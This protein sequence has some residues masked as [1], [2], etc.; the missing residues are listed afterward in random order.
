MSHVRSH[1][2]F[3]EAWF[4]FIYDSRVFPEFI[5]KFIVYIF[6]V[7]PFA[8]VGVCRAILSKLFSLSY[9][10]ICFSKFLTGP[11]SGRS[12]WDYYVKYYQS[13]QTLLCIWIMLCPRLRVI[14][15]CYWLAL[16]WM[17][18][19]YRYDWFKVKKQTKNKLVLLWEIYLWKVLASTFWLC[20]DLGARFHHLHSTSIYALITS[21]AYYYGLPFWITHCYYF[22]TKRFNFVPLC[23]YYMFMLDK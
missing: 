16:L 19:N 3:D 23:T 8:N 21:Y 15:K 17:V 12:I 7:R 5:R 22:I 1:T 9:F 11:L 20:R 18:E 2:E 14:K 6:I 4:L 13:H 10:L